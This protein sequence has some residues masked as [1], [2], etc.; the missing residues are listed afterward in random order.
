MYIV[1]PDAEIDDQDMEQLKELLGVLDHQ[2]TL[3]SLKQK[4]THP[5]EQNIYWDRLSYLAGLGFVMCQQYINVNAEILTL[6]SQ[7]EALK[8]SI[9]TL[10]ENS[11]NQIE[12]FWDA[13]QEKIKKISR[14]ET[15]VITQHL[16]ETKK[17]LAFVKKEHDKSFV[18][19]NAMVEETET[20]IKEIRDLNLQGQC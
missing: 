9:N 12:Q 20:S 17:I 8:T 5:P 4:K 14:E 10:T 11:L 16:S 13:T 18:H 19:I 7:K 6:T 2:F 15:E 1:F 3:N